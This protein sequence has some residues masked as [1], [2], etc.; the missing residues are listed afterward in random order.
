MIKSPSKK[1][2]FRNLQIAHSG[3][4]QNKAINPLV[5]SLRWWCSAEKQVLDTAVKTQ[6]SHYL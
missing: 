4:M 2:L 3:P 1:R 6:K 5:E